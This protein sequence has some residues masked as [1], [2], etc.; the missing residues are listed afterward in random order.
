M[1]VAV[2]YTLPSCPACLKLKEDWTQEG[3]K[4]EERQVSGNQDVLDEALKLGDM[5]PI[6]VHPDGRVEVGYKNMI[7]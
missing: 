5:V 1:S 3:I 2:I 7:G 4:F 6:I